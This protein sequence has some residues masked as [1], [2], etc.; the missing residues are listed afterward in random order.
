MAFEFVS[1]L[2]KGLSL[3]STFL[4]KWYEGEDPIADIHYYRNHR[5][6][7]QPFSLIIK[8]KSWVLKDLF[9]GAHFLFNVPDAF[10]TTDNTPCLQKI[11]IPRAFL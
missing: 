5:H 6:H 10:Y 11:L 9:F 2:L 7:C 8:Q 1:C 3:L 4:N